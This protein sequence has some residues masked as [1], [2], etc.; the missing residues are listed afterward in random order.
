M[1]E[2]S[3]KAFGVALVVAGVVFI[4]AGQLIPIIRHWPKHVTVR[5]GNRVLNDYWT[6]NKVVLPE[7]RMTLTNGQIQ[8][9]KVK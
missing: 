3:K 6:T 4:V 1:N 2:Q 9:V 5:L 7:W 8:P